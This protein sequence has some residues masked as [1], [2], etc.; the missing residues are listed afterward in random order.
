MPRVLFVCAQNRLRSPTAEKVFGN[1]PDFEVASAGVALG[2][3]VP[4]S[5][6]LLE[7]ADMIFVM[8]PAHR[9][10]LLR[11]FRPHLKGKRVICLNIPDEFQYMDPALIQLL[12]VRVDPFFRAE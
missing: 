1:R 9:K 6:E 12:E 4:V 2:A 5:A 8:E 7:W 3:E 10:A 11:R